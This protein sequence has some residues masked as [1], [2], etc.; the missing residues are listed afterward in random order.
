[1]RSVFIAST[2]PIFNQDLRL[3][4]YT[5]NLLGS[6]LTTRFAIKAFDM[7]VLL[8]TYDRKH[9]LDPL[10]VTEWSGLAMSPQT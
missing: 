9:L 7:A 6:R 3:L 10:E 5:E 2:P 8:A 4:A 1:V